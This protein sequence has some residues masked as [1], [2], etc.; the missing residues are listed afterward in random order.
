MTTPPSRFQPGD[1]LTRKQIHPVLGGSGYAGI[2]PAVEKRNVLIFSD[3]EIGKRYGYRDGWL[4]ED[5]D[6]GPIFTYTGA[7]K[8]GDQTLDGGNASILRH[9]EK[10]RTL[11]LFIAIGKVPG[12]DTRTHKYIGKFKVDER[13][14]FETREAKDERGNDRNVIVFR[15]RPIGP[16][17]REA[18][19][20]LQLAPESRSRFNQT[21]GRF[22]RAIRRQKRQLQRQ[23]DIDQVEAARDDLADAFEERKVA[24][25][26]SI[27]QLELSMRNSSSRLMLDLYDR[28]N[29]TVY[30]P[31]GSAASESI[32]QALAQLLLARSHLRSLTHDQ[33][34]H[35]M[36]LSPAL[37]RE[38]L[39]D[40]L[41]EHGIGIVYRNGSGHFT[42]F[43]GSTTTSS[44]AARS[45]R[46]LD[47]PVP[48]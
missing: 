36:V 12:T 10:G 40:L 47:C 26:E 15:L 27:G 19:D 43:E 17:V 30:E 5:D 38:D 25:G 31:T 7:G 34:L 37:P 1:I 2:C 23:T 16:Y 48:A 28:G 39:R 22:A 9:A 18:A 42:E 33:P 11:H 32:T 20:T 46:C 44:S 6:L 14:P 3:G 21:T 24:A 45:L 29:N 13:K 41:A 8:Q 35:L 4:S